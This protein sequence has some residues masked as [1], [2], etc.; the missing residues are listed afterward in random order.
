MA[1]T[2]GQKL[3]RLRR[4]KNKSMGDLADYLDLSVSYVSEVERGTRAPFAPDVLQK[5]ARF[6]KCD[7]EELLVSAAESRGA[8]EL[9]ASGIT[10]TKREIG[11]ALMR[12]WEDMTEDDAQQIQ[13]L[14]NAILARQKGAQ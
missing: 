14:V 6:L 13:L 5:V 3:R 9:S 11:A 12:S 2:F 4:E 7:A 10:K 1:E 8:F